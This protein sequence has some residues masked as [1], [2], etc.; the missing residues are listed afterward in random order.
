MAEGSLKLVLG[1]AVAA[2]AGSPGGPNATTAVPTP[3]SRHPAPGPSTPQRVRIADAALR[4]VA[5][6]GV[7]K[8]TVD[9]VAREAGCSRATV[10]RV[11]PGGKDEV[12]EAMVATE[13]AR[14]FSTLA[15]R[16][17]EA[18]DIEEVLVAGIVEAARAI[19]THPALT[20]L[21]AHEPETV[22]PHLCF[23]KMEGVLAAAAEFSGPFLARW[24]DPGD[25]ARVGE[26]AA[27]TVVSYVACPALGV[28]LRDER[29]ATHLVETFLLPGILALSGPAEQLPG[30]STR[31]RSPRRSSSAPVPA[32]DLGGARGAE[33]GPHPRPISTIHRS[34]DHDSKG[35]G[36]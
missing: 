4:C 31:R 18:A 14:F 3:P 21:L 12:L 36:R 35:D 27:R 1:G 16:M 15:V 9:D 19:Q 24:L 26:W 17:G 13:V 29:T 5:R 33:A 25:A 8:S 7:A 6:Q 28:D 22:L 11:F 10:Y 23:Q 20:Y 2:D 34:T 32:D 30:H